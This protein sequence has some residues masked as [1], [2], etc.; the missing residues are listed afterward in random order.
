MIIRKNLSKIIASFLTFILIFVS[1]IH[2]A[3]A[4]SHN[5]DLVN[6]NLQDVEILTDNDQEIKLKTS[7]EGFTG[8]LV[9][10][11]ETLE[12]TLTTYN[13]PMEPSNLLTTADTK[14]GGLATNIS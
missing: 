2:P 10:N 12:I 11:K 8:I 13:E 4:E 1:V 9:Q 7:V 3:S 14:S 6:V 5:T